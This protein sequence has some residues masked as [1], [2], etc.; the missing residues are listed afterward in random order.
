MNSVVVYIYCIFTI[1]VSLIQFFLY[2]HL[3]APSSNVD[4]NQPGGATENE[5]R[6]RS[7]FPNF[8]FP[9]GS[10]CNDVII[11]RKSSKFFFLT[12][13]LYTHLDRP[14]AIGIDSTECDMALSKGHRSLSIFSGNRLRVLLYVLQPFR[15][16]LG[17]SRPTILKN[18]L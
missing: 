10:N 16:H 5:R 9:P 6:R 11:T 7:L 14:V 1:A 4:R 15:L 12:I 13:L 2:K 8:N 3:P 18:A 17:I